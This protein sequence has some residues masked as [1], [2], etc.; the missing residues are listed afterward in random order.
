[1]KPKTIYQIETTINRLKATHSWLSL[2]SVK[3]TRLM[4]GD[5]TP[6]VVCDSIYPTAEIKKEYLRRIKYRI[7]ELQSEVMAMKNEKVLSI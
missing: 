5:F 7:I 1:M 2:S 6:V 4:I 3:Q